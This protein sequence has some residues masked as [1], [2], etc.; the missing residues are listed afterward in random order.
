[1]Q[2]IQTIAA[3][4]KVADVAAAGSIGA[5]AAVNLTNINLYVQI[6]AGCVAVVAGTAAAIFHAYKT[7]QLYKQRHQEGGSK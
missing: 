5:A 3:T 1:M 2:H 6:A 4:T 7:Y